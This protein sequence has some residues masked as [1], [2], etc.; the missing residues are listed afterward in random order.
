LF[1]YAGDDLNDFENS[2]PSRWSK[3]GDVH[4]PLGILLYYDKD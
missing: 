1:R 2:W 3:N 4:C